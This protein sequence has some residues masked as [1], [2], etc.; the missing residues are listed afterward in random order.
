MEEELKPEEVSNTHVSVSRDELARVSKLVRLQIPE[1]EVDTYCRQLADV[2]SWFDMLAEVDTI[3][4]DPVLHGGVHSV[5]PLRQDEV[6]E[7]DMRDQ[8][9]CNASSSEMGFFVVKKV[10]E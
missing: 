1:E 2:V 5:L 4:V 8:I 6:H 7:G 9:L 10:V 3:D